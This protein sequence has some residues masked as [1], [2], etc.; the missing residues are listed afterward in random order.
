MKIGLVG[1][2]GS[3]KSTLFEW[4]TGERPDPAQAHRAQSAMCVVPEPR[5]EPLC[6]I[7]QPKKVTLASLEIVDLPGLSRTHEGSASTLA[8]IRDAGCLVM[9]LAAYDGADP[10]ADLKS[11]EEDLLIADLDIVAGRIE[12]LEEQVKKPRPNR[13]ELQ[14]E[15]ESL[16]PLLAALEQGQALH[17]LEL[18]PEQQRV[19]KSFQL[20]SQKPRLVIVNTSDVE[21]QPE[22]FASLAPAGTPLF[23]F[24]L[25]LE[26]ELASMDEAERAEFCE[27][28]QVQPYDRDPVIRAIMERSGQML[29]FT[30]GDREVRTWMIRVGGTALEAAGN[31]HTDLAQGFIR[32]ET[33]NIDDLVRLGSEREVKAA[34]LMRQ[35][36]KDYVIQ[37]G[38]IILIRHN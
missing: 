13:D 29:F 37:Q 16:Q 1:Y 21:D 7:Y 38:D 20:L 2:Q 30:A 27:E 36:P 31:I 8:M 32:A 34:G 17:H 18:T 25:G 10:G 14:A 19:T 28:M 4:L 26:M 33:M 22:R 9:V 12:R 15:L 6:E 23:A 35:E 24:S 3:G 5:V 11:F